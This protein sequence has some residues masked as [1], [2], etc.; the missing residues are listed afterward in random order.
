MNPDARGALLQVLGLVNNQ[1]GVPVAEVL[2]YEV[3]YVVAGFVG[4]PAG[5][6]RKCCMP[7]GLASPACSA[8]VQQFFLGRSARTAGVGP[9]VRCQRV[10][11]PSTIR[12]TEAMVRTIAGAA[13]L[14]SPTRRWKATAPAK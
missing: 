14:R 5:Q 12:A 4:L 6:P 9:A 13:P 2:D 7:A 11:A 1:Y 8:I 10:A 3:P